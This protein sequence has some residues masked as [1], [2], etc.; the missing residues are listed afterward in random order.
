[1]EKVLGMESND[2]NFNAKGI[3]LTA[4]N[5]LKVSIEEANEIK[6]AIEKLIVHERI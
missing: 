1:M 5:R 4:S 6:T 3:K 2:G